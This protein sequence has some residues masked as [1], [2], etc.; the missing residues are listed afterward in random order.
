MEQSVNLDQSPTVPKNG[1]TV[2]FSGPT[3]PRSPVGLGTREYE[4][5]ESKGE[6]GFEETG[7]PKSNCTKP[8]G[9]SAS[10]KAVAEMVAL[11]TGSKRMP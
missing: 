11:L 9:E 8:N 7:N 2:P 3:V 5:Y 1:S 4:S 6:K 10:Q